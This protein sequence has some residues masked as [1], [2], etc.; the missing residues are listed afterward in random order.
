MLV[1]GQ[2]EEEG[3]DK[4]EE[5]GE[6]G[7]VQHTEAPLTQVRPQPHRRGQSFESMIASLIFRPN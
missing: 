6:E 1:N 3:D 2:G 5:E 7:N 4:E